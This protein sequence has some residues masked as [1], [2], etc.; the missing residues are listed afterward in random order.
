MLNYSSLDYLYN[1]ADYSSAYIDLNIK[2]NT[3]TRIEL[4]AAFTESSYTS[5]SW[6][7]STQSGYYSNQAFYCTI[8]DYGLRFSYGDFQKYGAITDTTDYRDDVRRVYSFYNGGISVN[9][10]ETATGTKHAVLT[11][12]SLRWFCD[13]YSTNTYFSRAHTVQH[14]LYELK[15]Y[16]GD[17]LLHDFVPMFRWSDRLPGLYDKITNYFCSPS[18]DNSIFVF[19]K[20]LDHYSDNLQLRTDFEVQ[21]PIHNFLTENSTNFKIIDDAFTNLLSKDI[22]LVGIISKITELFN[23]DVTQK[24][25]IYALLDNKVDAETSKSLVATLLINKLEADYTKD[26]M[27]ILLANKTDLETR[28]KETCIKIMLAY[29]TKSEVDELIKQG[30]AI[31]MDDYYTKIELDALIP[32]KEDLSFIQKFLESCTTYYNNL[33]L[34]SKLNGKGV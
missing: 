14:S 31:S 9:G 26:E 11:T 1:N 13:I 4:D 21:E 2:V 24:K 8:G 12:L 17:S 34:F 16:E 23:Y 19:G 30:E 28:I 6:L 10:T 18:G 32:S 20:I 7:F 29:Y 25:S 22:V 3:N 15:I 27:T 33:G 5:N